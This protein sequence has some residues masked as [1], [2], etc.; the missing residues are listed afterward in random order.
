MN[1]L[2][3]CGFQKTEAY[4]N[5]LLLSLKLCLMKLFLEWTIYSNN[6]CKCTQV[7]LVCEILVSL[8]MVMPTTIF[9]I[10]EV[11]AL[12]Q[13]LTDHSVVKFQSWAL[14]INLSCKKG[15]EGGHDLRKDCLSSHIRISPTHGRWRKAA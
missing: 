5:K 10:E 2:L 3:I 8:L 12:S 7:T 4:S 1:N 13:L 11:T 9:E 14:F 15:N 6:P